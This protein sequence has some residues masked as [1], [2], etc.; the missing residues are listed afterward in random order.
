MF[1]HCLSHCRGL[2]QLM[3]AEFHTVT[4]K[5]I[6]QLIFTFKYYM[7]RD[8]GKLSSSAHGFFGINRV[9]NSA[10][11][12]NISQCGLRPLV[13][14]HHSL[15]CQVENL[16]V[17]GIPCFS[18]ALPT[19]GPK[20]LHVF[21]PTE[22]TVHVDDKDSESI[23]EGFMDEVDHKYALKQQEGERKTFT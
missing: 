15:A 6:G 3:E 8:R 13:K 2:G 4:N 11:S 19:K 22:G 21:L 1:T 12:L 7:A 20:Q 18:R 5:V 23:D 17:K 9:T 10:R 16:S 14:Q